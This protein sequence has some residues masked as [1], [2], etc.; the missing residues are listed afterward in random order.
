MAA[1]NNPHFDDAFLAEVK[2]ILLQDKE[3]LESELGR[4]AK[5]NPHAEG[6]YDA[7]MP[8]YGSDEDDNVHEVADYTVNKS[9][10]ISLE[11]NLRDVNK[12]LERIEDGTYGM[13]KYTGKPIEKKRLLARPTSSSSV[14][15][16]KLLTNEQ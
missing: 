10:E 5:P 14:D 7:N 12:A 4:F 16:K 6:D 15:A 2:G 11:K 9:L 1:K 8:E 13:C 3:R